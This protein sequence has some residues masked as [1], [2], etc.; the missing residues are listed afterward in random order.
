MI[1]YPPPCVHLHHASH[2]TVPPF[3]LTF[4]LTLLPRSSHSSA[5][6]LS[7]FCPAPLTLL[8]SLALC[9][10]TRDLSSPA[11]AAVGEW[12][13]SKQQ[14]DSS[15]GVSFS[16][17]QLSGNAPGAVGNTAR[18]VSGPQVGHQFVVVNTRTAATSYHRLH[19]HMCTVGR[20][21]CLHVCKYSA[22][23]CE[24]HGSGQSGVRNVAVQCHLLK[25]SLV[26]PVSPCHYGCEV[27][28]SMRYSEVRHGCLHTGVG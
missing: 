28:G 13:G 1:V 23:V 26:V 8:P 3:S 10:P 17:G 22:M 12:P 24:C 16:N 9:A 15:R 25:Q 5:P 19:S 4:L 11:P 2:V 6:L 27:L 20:G 14:G 21:A 18:R 7:P